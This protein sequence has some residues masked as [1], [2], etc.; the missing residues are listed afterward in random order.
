MLLADPV[1]RFDTLAI[2]PTTSRRVCASFSGVVL[3]V[4]SSLAGGSPLRVLLL[5]SSLSSPSSTFAPAWAIVLVLASRRSMAR[6]SRASCRCAS[7][8][9][10]SLMS[11]G[12]ARR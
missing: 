5:L 9:L 11:V 12:A 6:T 4:K 1:G 7:S 2:R 10:V 8:S 3:R